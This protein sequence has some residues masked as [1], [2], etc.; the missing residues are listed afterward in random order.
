M[1]KTIAFTINC[2]N[3][4]CAESPGV[5]CE[6]VST[7]RFG[8]EFVCALFPDNDLLYTKLEEKDGW[9][10]RCDAC[11]RSEKIIK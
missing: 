3:Q 7:K 5:F 11:I 8:L 9:L 4:T 10:Q 2:G 1:V 6:F